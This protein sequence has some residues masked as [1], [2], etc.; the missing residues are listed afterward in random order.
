MRLVN[1][2]VILLGLSLLGACA[3]VGDIDSQGSVNST[4]PFMP[5]GAV[6]DAPHGYKDMCRDRPGLC[7]DGLRA[8]SNT[9]TTPPPFLGA[10]GGA[11]MTDQSATGAIGEST[12]PAQTP[13]LLQPAVLRSSEAPPGAGLDGDHRR[14]ASPPQEDAQPVIVEGR[15]LPISTRLRMLETVDRYVNGNVRQATDMEIYGVEEYWTRSG[16][17]P[18]ARGD[19]EDLAIEKRMELIDQGYPASDLFYAVAYRTDIGLHAVLIAHTELGDLVLDSRSPYVVLWNHAPYTWIKRQ[20]AD[21]PSLWA[22]VDTETLGRPP[23]QVAA[24]DNA[25]RSRMA[26]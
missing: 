4:A 22:L 7:V 5:V 26:P 3:S 19:C 24:L 10:P 16:T 8:A 13:A 25:S 12:R 21:N 15:R 14:L 1:L 11:A 18:G 20:S 2:P 17:G 23:L 6:V 9:R